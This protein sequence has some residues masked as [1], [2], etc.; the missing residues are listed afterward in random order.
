MGSTPA[1]KATGA[2]KKAAPRASSSSSSSSPSSDDKAPQPGQIVSWTYQDHYTG[3]GQGEA[4]QRG[5][6]LAVDGGVAQ[7]VLF[8]N[9]AELPLEQLS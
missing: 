8:A 5:L 4:T 3:D 6:V 9:V 7:V 2:A 1:K